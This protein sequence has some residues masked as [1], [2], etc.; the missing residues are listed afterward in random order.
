M[1]NGIAS[2]VAMSPLLNFEN[3]DSFIRIPG[4]Y[5]D[6]IAEGHR[7]QRVV[8]CKFIAMHN[9]GHQIGLALG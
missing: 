3:D 5:I 9:S 7:R 6:E 1:P 2:K 8:N 4:V